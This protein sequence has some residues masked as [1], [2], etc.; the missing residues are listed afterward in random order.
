MAAETPRKRTVRPIFLIYGVFALLISLALAAFAFRGN[1]FPA[2]A[3][4]T[5][6]SLPV[7][8]VTPTLAP[9]TVTVGPGT[10]TPTVPISAT[11]AP[12]ATA[13][14]IPT[15]TSTGGIGGVTVENP[16]G[17]PNEAL[18]VIFAF[19][20]LSGIASI[21]KFSFDSVVAIARFVGRFRRP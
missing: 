12:T 13:A 11:F 2:S 7:V 6:T 8:L 5:A 18:A 16:L 3:E 1:Y 10:P 15:A 21:L 14:P 17:L 4:P 9:P 20:T 19:T